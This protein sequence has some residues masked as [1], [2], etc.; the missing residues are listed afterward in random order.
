MS[1]ASILKG[2]QQMND[3]KGNHYQNHNQSLYLHMADAFIEVGEHFILQ[4]ISKKKLG[5]SIPLILTA[6]IFVLGSSELSQKD[7]YNLKFFGKM[8]VM[9]FNEWF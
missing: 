2:F 3:T 4:H 9:Y 1:S 8:L 7:V 5:F 6:C